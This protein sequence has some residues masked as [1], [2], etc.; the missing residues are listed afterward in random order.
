MELTFK[1]TSELKQC[2]HC[3]I[4]PCGSCKEVTYSI[5]NRATNFRDGFI[6]HTL[7]SPY[8]ELCSKSD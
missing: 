6:K 4:M 1:I 8:S 7:F 3:C 5:H 2:G